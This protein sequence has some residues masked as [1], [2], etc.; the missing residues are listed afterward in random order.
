MKKINYDKVTK[1]YTLTLKKEE[2]AI[3]HEMLN[4]VKKSIT[5]KG[6]NDRAKKEI[7]NEITR[8]KICDYFIQG[9]TTGG[10]PIDVNGLC[11]LLK[12]FSRDFRRNSGPE[13]FLRE[14]MNKYYEDNIERIKKNTIW[15][16]I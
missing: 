1:E 8:R 7:E 15:V 6:Y 13:K 16:S 12:I 9:F 3:L 10:Q 14:S 11:S 5:L 4:T 2:V